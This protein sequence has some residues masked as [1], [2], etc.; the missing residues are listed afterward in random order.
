MPFPLL[1]GKHLIRVQVISRTA[2]YDQTKE[3]Q[4]ELSSESTK[5]LDIK[6]AGR[7]ENLDLELR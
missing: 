4:T 2:G 7:G 3:V 6:F 1:P 5:T